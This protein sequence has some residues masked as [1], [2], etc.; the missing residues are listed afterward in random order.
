MK[1]SEEM[2]R[3]SLAH[4]VRSVHCFSHLQLC[5]AVKENHRNERLDKIHV[6]LW[7]R[8]VV[9]GDTDYT[10]DTLILALEFSTLQNAPFLSSVRYR[11]LQ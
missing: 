11:V 10:E 8:R 6:C 4:V 7:R 5:S 9:G 2:F 1:T 3:P